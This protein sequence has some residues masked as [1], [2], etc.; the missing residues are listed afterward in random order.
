MV[1]NGNIHSVIPSSGIKMHNIPL[2]NNSHYRKKKPTDF[3]E[4]SLRTEIRIMKKRSLPKLKS[5]DKESSLSSIRLES[6][7]VST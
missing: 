2:E 4:T 6:S 1:N 7:R 5:K 3:S